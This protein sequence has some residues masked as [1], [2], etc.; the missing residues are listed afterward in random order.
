MLRAVNL[1][2]S[3]LDAPAELSVPAAVKFMSDLMGLSTEHSPERPMSL[4]EQVHALVEATGLEL[5]GEGH[6]ENEQEQP[7]LNEDLDDDSASS[8]LDRRL[9]QSKLDLHSSVQFSHSQFSCASILS[10]CACAT[11]VCRESRLFL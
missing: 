10:L 4:P 5:T 2:R 9:E 3:A 6:E 1:L 11:F 8:Q 7:I